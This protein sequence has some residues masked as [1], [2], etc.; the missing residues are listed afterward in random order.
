VNDTI[1]PLSVRILDKEYRVACGEGEE[2]ALLASA[3][4]LD[5]R[6]REVRSSGKVIGTDKIAV[7]VALNLAHDLIEQ[8][9]RKQDEAD[10]AGNRLRHLRERIEVALNDSNQLEL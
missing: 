7:I 4:F 6:M 2:D 3:R 8:K 1:K 9:A 10:S 5:K